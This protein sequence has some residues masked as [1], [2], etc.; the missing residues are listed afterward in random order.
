M[1]ICQSVYFA[2][3]TIF[4][5]SICLHFSVYTQISKC[6]PLLLRTSFLLHLTH[7]THFTLW[8]INYTLGYYSFWKLIFVKKVGLYLG[9]FKMTL[10]NFGS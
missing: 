2:F 7:K 8:I 9:N 3:C 4:T 1:Q 6:D 5:A 10:F